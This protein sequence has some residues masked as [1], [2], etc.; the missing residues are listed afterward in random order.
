M[1]LLEARRARNFA[2]GVS[3]LAAA[4][5]GVVFMIGG[6]PTAQRIHIAAL[7]LCAAVMGTYA[8]V[9]R[10]PTRYRPVDMVVLASFGMIANVTGYY[11][12]GVYSAYLAAVAASGYAFASSVSHR[13]GLIGLT[14]VAIGGHA[15]LGVAQL[16]GWM[17]ARGLAEA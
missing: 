4:A 13:S 16:G 8:L 17:Q 7:L 15:G 3:I 10:D 5:A 14:I 9:R 6:D 1:Q 2:T 11:Y 12:W